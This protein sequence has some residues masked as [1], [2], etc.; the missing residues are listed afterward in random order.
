M[1]LAVVLG[2][3]WEDTKSGRESSVFPAARRYLMDLDVSVPLYLFLLANSQSMEL[4][5]VRVGGHK[6]AG[7]C[8]WQN[9][10]PSRLGDYFGAVRVNSI[11]AVLHISFCM[12]YGTNSQGLALS[13]GSGPF[14][15]QNK[16]W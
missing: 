16:I 14:V 12:S 10:S 13:R 3:I 7:H 15:T 4:L 5:A 9:Y 1:A 8:C 11:S 6:S 2:G